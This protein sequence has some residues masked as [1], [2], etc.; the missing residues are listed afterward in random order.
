[1]EKLYSRIRETAES[2]GIKFEM[3]RINDH[4]SDS[5]IQIPRSSI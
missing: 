3:V 1:M 2:I 5:T 4:S